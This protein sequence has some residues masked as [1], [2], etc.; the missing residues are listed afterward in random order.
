MTVT[1]LDG[2]VVTAVT[3][4]VAVTAPYE[5]LQQIRLADPQ[6]KELLTQLGFW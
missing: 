4:D 5:V 3:V 1:M 2:T 6:L